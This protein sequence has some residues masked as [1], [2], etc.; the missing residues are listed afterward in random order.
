M[1]MLLLEA[2]LPLALIAAAPLIRTYIKIKYPTP[3]A[4]GEILPKLCVVAADEIRTYNELLEQERR[5]NPDLRRI[6]RTNQIRI[7]RSYLGQMA[8]NT[9]LFQ[10]VLRFE[11]MKIDPAKSSF[12]YESRETLVLDL[13]DESTQLRWELTRAKRDLA[14]C[15]ALGRVVD[16]DSLT[17]LLGNYKQ[18]EQDFIA[19]TDMAEDTCYRDMLIERLGLINWNLVGGESS[20]PEPA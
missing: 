13:V 2:M 10:E 3:R 6:L 12:D 20:T 1:I 11:A 16:Q 4:L 7:N 5:L 15:A 8:W 19:L 18:L 14:I 9:S 17:T